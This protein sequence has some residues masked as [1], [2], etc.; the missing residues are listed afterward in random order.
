MSSRRQVDVL[1]RNVSAI[2]LR[3]DFRMA[4]KPLLEF[5]RQAS[6]H[7]LW[8]DARF[9]SSNKIKPLKPGLGQSAIRLEGQG[10]PEIG[11]IAAKRVAVEAWRGYTCNRVRSA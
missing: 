7:A 11:R 9:Q 2:A 5:D 8:R 10:Q 3:D 4:A 1:L 6:L